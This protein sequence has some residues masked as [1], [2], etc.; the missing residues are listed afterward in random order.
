MELKKPRKER[1]LLLQLT[2]L[3]MMLLL[4]GLKVIRNLNLS[5]FNML[6]LGHKLFLNSTAFTLLSFNVP[7]CLSVCVCVCVCSVVFVV[8]YLATQT[9]GATV[10][11]IFE[12]RFTD[13]KID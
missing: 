5:V 2:I 11:N 4:K 1:K 6:L 12:V 13:T 7:C 3:M 9:G 10:N 8:E